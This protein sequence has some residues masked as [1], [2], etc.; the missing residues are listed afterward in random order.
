MSLRIKLFRTVLINA[1]HLMFLSISV[2]LSTKEKI[3]NYQT[4]KDNCIKFIYSYIL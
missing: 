3:V 1:Y 4:N 2:A